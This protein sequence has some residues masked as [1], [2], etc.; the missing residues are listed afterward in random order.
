MKV[1]FMLRNLVENENKVSEDDHSSFVIEI[2][3]SSYDKNNTKKI[4]FDKN[5]NKLQGGSYSSKH[6]ASFAPERH[7]AFASGRPHISQSMAVPYGDMDEGSFGDIEDHHRL[8]QTY[9]YF[10]RR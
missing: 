9:T 2:I 5:L 10:E 1:N 4:K 3:E 8:D 7:R 6:T